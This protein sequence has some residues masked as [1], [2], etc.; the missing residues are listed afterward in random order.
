MLSYDFLSWGNW[1]ES[2]KTTSPRKS[3]AHY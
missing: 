3:W 2:D 1:Y